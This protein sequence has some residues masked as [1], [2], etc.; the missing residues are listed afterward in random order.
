MLSSCSEDLYDDTINENNSVVAR[1][2]SMEDIQFKSNPK[3]VKSVANLKQIQLDKSN[4]KYEY[5]EVYDFYIDEDNGVYLEKDNL[6]SYTFPVYKTETDST[7]TNIIFNKTPTGAYDVILGEYDIKKSEFSDITAAELAQSEVEYTN[8]IGRFRGPELIC[9]ETGEYLYTLEHTIETGYNYV[10]HWYTTGSYCFW[11]NSDGGGG[12]D[13]M[14]S[15]SSTGGNTGGGILTGPVDSPHGGGGGGGT[16]TFP[17]TPCGRLQKGTSSNT[18]RQ[19]FKGL[20]NDSNFNLPYETGFA[21]KMT[22]GILSYSHLQAPNGKS[23]RVP[24]GSLNY[25]HVHNNHLVYDSNGDVAYDGGIKILSPADVSGLITTCQSASVSANINPTEAFGIMIS[26]EAIFS[27][28]LLEPLTLAELGQVNPKW[29]TFEGEYK[30]KA[31]NIIKNP[32][33]DATGRKNALQKMLLTLLKNVGL[34]NKV[35]LFEGEVESEP[36]ELPKINW[37]KKSLNP[38][39]PNASPI[40]TPC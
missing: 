28:T 8:L 13:G 7:I 37:T 10:L 17:D 12:S 33:L 16:Q 21:Q 1:K 4:S 25:T 27:I 29:K 2:I 6:E 15:G 3:L 9:I 14:G 22:N 39:N 20:N 24:Q 40:E 23:L 31:G 18:Y 35:G 32:N 19:K 36:G 5:S 11:S 30:E 26:N 34:E 38:A